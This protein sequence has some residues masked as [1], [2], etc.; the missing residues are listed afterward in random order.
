MKTK[1]VLLLLILCIGHHQLNASDIKGRVLNR[2]KQPLPYTTISVNPGEL[3]AICDNNGNFVLEN[4]KNGTYN[5]T[6]SYLGFNTIKKTIN[7]KN[8]DLNLSFILEENDENIAEVSVTADR[9]AREVKM[10]SVTAVKVDQQFISENASGSLMQTLSKIPGVSSIDV[11]SSASKPIIRGMSFNRVAVINNGVKL[12]GQQWGETHGLE[13]DQYAI[14]NVK[15]IKGPASIQFGSDALAGVIEILP[16]NIPAP[17]SMVGEVKLIGKTNNDLVGTSFLIKQRK[18]QYYY[19]LRA[20]Y[21]DF[22]DLMVPK[23]SIEYNTYNLILNNNVKNTAGREAAIT[24]EIGKLFDRGNTSFQISNLYRKT[25]FYADAFGVEIRTQIPID[26]DASKRDIQIP[27][28]MVN[29]F[30]VSNHTSINYGENQLNT[31]IAYQNNIHNDYD[32]LTDITGKTQVFPDDHLSTGLQ[33]H[34]LS[35]NANYKIKWSTATLTSGFSGQYIKNLRSGFNFNIPAYEKAIGGIFTHYQKQLRSETFFDAGLRYDYGFIDVEEYINPRNQNETD[36]ILSTPI[37]R[38]FSSITGTIGISSQLSEKLHGKA[39]FGKSFRVP[40][41]R[42]LSAYGMIWSSARFEIG[43]PDLN[44]E[45][46]YQLDGELSFLSEYIDLTGGAF[47]SYFSNY[48][49]PHPSGGFNDIVGAGQ[50][51]NYQETEAIRTGGEL[52]LFVK[53]TANLGFDVLAEYVYALNLDNNAPLPFTPPLSVDASV[54][55]KIKLSKT[56]AYLLN[57]FLGAKHMAEQTRV[58]Q[59]EVPGNITNAS[60]I[61]YLG[62]SGKLGTKSQSP[63]FM[64]RVDNLLNTEYYNHLSIYRRINMPEAGRNIQLTVNIPFGN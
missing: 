58:V 10:Q 43:N 27:Y 1:T 57:T 38:N 29:H 37:N 24:T 41:I 34:T 54:N 42:E 20:T 55:Y 25:G 26:H 61:V 45:E 30:R 3:G 13:L 59:N 62:V 11:G 35:A 63:D 32:H 50:V 23:D 8:K 47:Y 56:R 53:P 18:N 60:T 33:L 4:L 36:S 14:E 22:A 51:Y 16:S 12:E 39:S 5:L 44:P 64:L 7:L 49:F 9:Y 46:V 40:S 17:N 31:N 48:I 2:H 52:S 28:Q 21:L 19:T 6:I 15:V